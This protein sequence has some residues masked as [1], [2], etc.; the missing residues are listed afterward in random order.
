MVLERGMEKRTTLPM[1]SLTVTDSHCFGWMRLI[2]HPVDWDMPNEPLAQ[3]PLV[4]EG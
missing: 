3:N 1:S 2:S 4:D